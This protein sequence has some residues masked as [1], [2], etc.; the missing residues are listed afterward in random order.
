MHEFRFQSVIPVNA[1]FAYDWHTREGAFERL[2]PPW[3]QV[4]VE[5]RQGTI[6]AG[7]V[8]F[9]FRIGPFHVRWRA[10]HYGGKPGVEF[11]DRL[12]AGPMAFWEHVHRFV[13]LGSREFRMEDEV[14]YRAFVRPAVLDDAVDRLFLRREMARMFR[15]RHRVLAHD[16]VRH[17]E[18]STTPLRFLVTG[19]TG[20]VGSTLCAFLSAGGHRVIRATRR[21]TNATGEVLWTPSTGEIKLDPE[22]PIDVVV[23]LA[24]ANV[25][26]RRWTA[27]RKAEIRA[28]RVMTTAKLAERVAQWKVLPKAFIV[29]SAIGFYGNRGDELLDEDS[30]AGEGF[31]ASVCREWEAASRPPEEAGIRVVRLRIGVVLSPRGGALR[32]L[33]WPFWL[34]LGGRT[35]T[36]RQYLSWITPD[37]LAA[38]ILFCA[39][40]DDLRGPVNAVSPHPVTN[41]TF[42]Q[43]LAQALGRPALLPFPASAVRWILGEMGEELILSSTRVRPTRLLQ[44]GFRFHFPTVEEALG[45]VLGTA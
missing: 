30:S 18:L 20:L 1:S 42:A 19:A 34:G 8:D 26:E 6:E 24:G 43:A 2:T 15:Y 38:V 37:D 14:R 45:H 31:L 36:G 10:E 16:L 22:Q 40:K 41:A 39:V 4:D 33:L 35:G 11:R 28:S 32:R 23:H 5:R 17:Q 25:G 21:E 7:E 13:P 9:R 3:T 44:S 12:V 29:A 27:D